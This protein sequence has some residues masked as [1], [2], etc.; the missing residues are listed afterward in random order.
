MSTESLIQKTKRASMAYYDVASQLQ[1][2]VYDR[3]LA[4]FAA[5]DQ[6]RDQIANPAQLDTYRAKLRR[7]LIE[8][9]G[10]LPFGETALD[11]QVTGRIQENGFCIEKIIFQ[12]RPACYVTANLYLPDRLD[13]PTGAVLFLCGHAREG[14]QY[15]TYQVVC[16]SLVE[17]GLIVLAQDP[18][19]QGERFGYYEPAAGISVMAGP[20]EEHDHAGTS[21]LL[22]GAPIARYFIHD[23]MRAI[24]YL[25]QR[26]DVDPER[27]GV[28]GSSGGG[29][30]TCLMMICDPRLAAAAPT[31]FL[32]SRRAYLFA[33]GAQDAEQIWP[34]FTALGY[35]HEDFLLAMAPRPVQVNAVTSDF[36]PIEGTR[37][38]VQRAARFWDMYG[39]ADGLT[40]CEDD[41]THMYTSHLAGQTAMFMARHLLGRDA[42]PNPQAIS[43]LEP[44]QLW[45]TPAGQVKL[46]F[47]AARF[48]FEENLA[49]HQAS[50]S[51]WKQLPDESRREQTRAWLAERVLANRDACAPNVRLLAV[52]RLKNLTVQ[53]CLWWS[54]P[55]L[56]NHA[57]RIRSATASAGPSPVVLALWDDGTLALAEHLKWIQMACA[58]GRQVWILDPS[59]VG[60][61]APGPIND[62][63]I[64][65]RYGT[66]FKLNDDL[67]WLGDS[68][69]AL[70]AFDVIRA[71]DMLATLP[72]C[73]LDSLQAVVSGRSS[74]VG[75]VAAL[76]DAR[77]RSLLQIGATVPLADIVTERYYDDER[78]RSLIIPG[79][80]QFADLP[81][82]DRWLADR[83]A[84][85]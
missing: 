38:S 57:Y 20:T 47:P 34:N 31:N 82:L 24:D 81:D 48:V 64:Q 37:R 75:K 17:A 79:L 26:P 78:V 5:G 43:C 66:L 10:G 83:L 42:N 36:F 22:T 9:L 11:A 56:M 74:A 29:T 4:A 33:G 84:I 30:Q 28:T 69:A 68:L 54:Q 46:A 80:L 67:I 41:S 18:V 3:S 23:A 77:I 62:R 53:S 55:G 6:R 72:D 32:T 71:I 85:S 12:A 7:D 15:E 16:R 52:D 45:C 27:I 13:G 58:Q 76:L 14:K 49:V 35:D 1:R 60:H 61:A 73:R 25:C 21:C 2:V 51:R 70:R 50:L 19:G 59:G 8:A 63:G 39:Q 65:E 44:Q 40:L